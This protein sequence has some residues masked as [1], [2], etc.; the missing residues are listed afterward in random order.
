MFE[1][2]RH[3]RFSPLAYIG[4]ARIPLIIFGDV[5][6]LMPFLMRIYKTVH[7]SGLNMCTSGVDT[8]IVVEISGELE[9]LLI[10]LFQAQ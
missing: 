6:R 8:P 10:N 7:N 9:Y 4:T 5:G 1:G 3:G 2:T